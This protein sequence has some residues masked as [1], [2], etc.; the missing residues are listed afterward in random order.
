MKTDKSNKIGMTVR[1]LL[2]PLFAL[3]LFYCQNTN[4]QIKN[5]DVLPEFPGGLEKMY[6]Y[7][8]QNLTYPTEAKDKQVEGKV[9][10]WFVIEEDGSISNVKAEKSELESPHK[11]VQKAKKECEQEGI[12][13]VS[14][15]PKWK[16]ALKDGKP[17]RV[18]YMVP[19]KFSLQ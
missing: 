8:G 3:T 19:I 9:Y 18:S 17:V 1:A 7:L 15:M 16:P 13:V 5:P 10:I 12:R 4:A 14:N 2:L 11:N 6:E